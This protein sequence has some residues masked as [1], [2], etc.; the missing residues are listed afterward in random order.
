MLCIIIQNFPSFRMYIDNL[1]TCIREDEEAI[2]RHEEAIVRVVEHKRK[3]VN[4]IFF[5]V[6]TINPLYF[7]EEML[8]RELKVAAPFTSLFFKI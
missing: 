7:K 5:G 2:T 6:Q 3:L 4:Q 1:V 8:D